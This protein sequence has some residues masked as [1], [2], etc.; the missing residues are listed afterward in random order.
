MTND[1]Y[2][3][4]AEL[5]TFLKLG[6]ESQRRTWYRVRPFFAPA[7]RQM[8]KHHTLYAAAKVRQ[9][10]EGKDDARSPLHKSRHLARVS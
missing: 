9:L 10:L 5:R 1:E 2:W 6:A 3:T 8:G 7:L 4:P